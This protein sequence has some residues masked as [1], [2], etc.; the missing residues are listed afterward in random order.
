[1]TRNEVTAYNSGVEA[2]LA[3][4]ERTAQAIRTAPGYRATRDE[5]AAEALM[6]MAEEGRALLIGEAG[7]DPVSVGSPS[8]G[9][10]GGGEL[11]AVAPAAAE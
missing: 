2:V 11:A 7:A 9:K 1:M 8:P 4:A 10:S 5:F 3:I 6:A